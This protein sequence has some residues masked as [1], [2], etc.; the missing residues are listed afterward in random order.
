MKGI[1]L[2]HAPW[3]DVKEMQERGRCCT[4]LAVLPDRESVRPTLRGV[5]VGHY[6]A[7]IRWDFNSLSL[8]DIAPRGEVPSLCPSSMMMRDQYAMS[9]FCPHRRATYN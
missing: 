9:T 1:R 7:S 2:S 3:I 4:W 8:F 6:P 5:G